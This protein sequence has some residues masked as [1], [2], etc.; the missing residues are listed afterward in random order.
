[1]I[2][3]GSSSASSYN[4]ALVAE[5]KEYVYSLN[6]W[7]L[8]T[9]NVNLPETINNYWTNPSYFICDSEGTES[10][11]VNFDEIFSEYTLEE[12][13]TAIYKPTLILTVSAAS[14]GEV[15]FCMR[16]LRI[17]LRDEIFHKNTYNYK[18]YGNSLEFSFNLYFNYVMD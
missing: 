5:R 15:N 6:Q 12:L 13:T 11:G 17:T 10:F 8:Q 4:M 3:I 18:Y 2:S 9:T 1:M 16:D 7:T 14:S